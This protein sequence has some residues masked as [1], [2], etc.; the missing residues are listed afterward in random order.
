MTYLSAL[1]FPDDK[2]FI[3]VSIRKYTVST[4]TLY[5]DDSFVFMVAKAAL[6]AG[7]DGL[8]D[9]IQCVPFTFPSEGFQLCPPSKPTR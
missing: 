1:E 2:R 8:L 9:A 6:P 7:W 3:N 4:D 5:P